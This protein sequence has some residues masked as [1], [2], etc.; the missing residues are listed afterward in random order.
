MPFIKALSSFW[1]S[2]RLFM[3]T[4]VLLLSFLIIFVVT[5]LFFAYRETENDLPIQHKY[6]HCFSKSQSRPS[7]LF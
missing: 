1:L 2:N 7:K 4:G 6:R 3:D 5:L